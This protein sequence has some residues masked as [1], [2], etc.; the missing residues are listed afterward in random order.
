MTDARKA[1]KELV[2]KALAAE[3]H[4][5]SPGSPAPGAEELVVETPPDP[6][7]GDLGFPMFAMAKRLRA[8]PPAIAA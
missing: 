4:E 3:I 2:A 7:M 1:W 6:T 8:S 5:R